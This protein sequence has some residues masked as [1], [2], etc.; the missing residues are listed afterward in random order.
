MLV[1]IAGF[2]S[3]LKLLWIISLCSTGPQFGWNCSVE[4]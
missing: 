4:C 2:C 3:S 1:K